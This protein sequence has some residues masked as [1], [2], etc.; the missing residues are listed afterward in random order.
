MGKHWLTHQFTCP[1]W[2]LNPKLAGKEH[3]RP[4]SL[5]GYLYTRSRQK[6]IQILEMGSWG[7]KRISNLPKVTKPQNDWAST[8]IQPCLTKTHAFL[9]YRTSSLPHLPSRCG[10][11]RVSSL[12]RSF[13]E[14][15]Q[16]ENAFNWVKGMSPKLRTSSLLG[17][18]YSLPEA[19]PLTP[20]MAVGW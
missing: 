8:R 18:L 12:W 11:R 7:L 5:Q 16:G 17:N 10:F 20:N 6:D 1:T 2:S 15:L 13:N 9:F 4:G 3:L 14:W 19:E